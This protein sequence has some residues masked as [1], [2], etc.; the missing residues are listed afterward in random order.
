[1]KPSK[2]ISGLLALLGFSGCDEIGKEMYGVP[3]PLMYGSPEVQFVVKG[4][5]TDADEKPLENVRIV[6]KIK[7]DEP[8]EGR[9]DR[10]VYRDTVYTDAKGEFLT[11]TRPRVPLPMELIATD[12]DGAENGGE[13]ESL[14]EE[15]H[16]NENMAFE[17]GRLV[18]TIDFTLTEKENENQ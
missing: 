9:Y 5:V 7:D 17:E 10:R 16:V 3:Q 11:N 4:A 14:S 1:M 6:L 18:K 2:I 8:V 12:I 13:F 15:F